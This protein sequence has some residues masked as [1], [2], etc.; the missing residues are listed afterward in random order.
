[1]K[2]TRRQLRKIIK[3]SMED[4]GNKFDQAYKQPDGSYRGQPDEP[5]RPQSFVDAHY[6]DFI[7]SYIR[8]SAGADEFMDAWL[9][10]LDDAGVRYD[11]D[12]LVELLE[13]AVENGEMEEGEIFLGERGAW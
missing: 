7:D 8:S 13:R 10:K 4:F 2:I 6:D 5:L 9:F 1:M 3:E 11:Q 12:D